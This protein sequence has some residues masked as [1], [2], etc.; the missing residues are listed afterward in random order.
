MI[1]LTRG[2]LGE[3]CRRTYAHQ[4]LCSLCYKLCVDKMKY[5][6]KNDFMKELTFKKSKELTFKKN[7]KKLLEYNKQVLLKNKPLGFSPQ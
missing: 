6:L 3:P 4:F 7:Q 2:G 1:W 5:L